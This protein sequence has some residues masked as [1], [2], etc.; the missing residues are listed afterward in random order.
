MSGPRLPDDAY[1]AQKKFVKEAVDLYISECNE[2][3]DMDVRITDR[4]E[5]RLLDFVLAVRNGLMDQKPE[6][7]YPFEKR[8][9]IDK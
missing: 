1:Q 7:Y 9:W 2:H 5:L 3:E 4:D 6:K 8:S